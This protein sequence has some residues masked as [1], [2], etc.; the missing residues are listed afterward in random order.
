[1]RPN[2]QRQSRPAPAKV[3]AGTLALV[4]GN[5]AASG[6]EEL[7]GFLVL[8]LPASLIV[9]TLA[10]LLLAR[11]AWIRL[12][13]A[14][15]IGLL[16]SLLSMQIIAWSIKP[17]YW[18]WEEEV[19]YFA[20]SILDIVLEPNPV[21]SRERYNGGSTPE[22]LSVHVRLSPGFHT[23]DPTFVVTLICRDA[24]I[25]VGQKLHKPSGGNCGNEA[26][27]ETRGNTVNLAFDIRGGLTDRFE[28]HLP[29]SNPAG[30][31]GSETT[32]YVRKLRTSD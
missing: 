13:L 30:V 8:G 27:V 26:T 7:S 4:A 12:A 22:A 28:L 32:T 3:C 16:T 21:G 19:P 24:W 31:T 14:V 1:M 15:P 6:S 18:L 11:G 10:V 29:V 25:R 2:S 20:S 5:A 9:T 17:Q 23:E